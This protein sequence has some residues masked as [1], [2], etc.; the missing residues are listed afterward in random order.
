MT[1]YKSIQR[2]SY[3]SHPIIEKTA[4]DFLDPYKSH[5]NLSWIGCSGATD[6]TREWSINN[7]KAGFVSSNN[8]AEC[9]AEHKKNGYR[10]SFKLGDIANEF[11]SSSISAKDY[12]PL[13]IKKSKHREILIS[14]LKE[15][16]ENN[17]EDDS[18]QKLDK[19]S[20]RGTN[21]KF[22]DEKNMYTTESSSNFTSYSI[23]DGKMSATKI[24]TVGLQ[25]TKWSMGSHINNYSTT[26][27]SS[28]TTVKL[29][30]QPQRITTE[31]LQKTHIILGHPTERYF[32][33]S[34]K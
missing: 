26:S 22:G 24:S 6:Y 14:K 15:K 21:W 3:Q 29:V 7:Q 10:T 32:Q 1:A 25:K 28:F 33:V 9:M 4:V 8:N 16:N 5:T 12:Q 20:L 11:K 17:A 2:L 13:H 31:E 23:E 19:E 34:T 30:Q 27:K 18:P